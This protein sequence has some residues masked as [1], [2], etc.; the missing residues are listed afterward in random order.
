MRLYPIV[1]ALG[2]LLYSCASL[3]K[4]NAPSGHTPTLG[5][6]GFQDH[7]LWN[8]QFQQI[9]NP[10]IS[11]PVAVSVQ[12]IPFSKSSYKKYTFSRR[13]AGLPQEISMADSLGKK[14]Y[15]LCLEITNKIAIRDALNAATNENVLS[16]LEKDD[17]YRLVHKLAVLPDTETYGLLAQANRLFLATDNEGILTLYVDNGNPPKAVDLSRMD[18]FD[19]HTLGFCWGKTPY[20]QKQIEALVGTSDPC[21]K[22]T[23]RKA[24]KLDETKSYL[25]L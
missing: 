7:S 19:Y 11:D 9:G 12:E 17:T 24:Y 16:Y 8:D 21:P 15:Y 14:S 10:L 22:N 13:Q 2:L 3:K 18:I 5:V 1:L 20:G 6:I 4:W 25:K 23:E